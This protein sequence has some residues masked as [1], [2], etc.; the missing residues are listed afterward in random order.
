MFSFVISN[1]LFL[2]Q[3]RYPKEFLCHSQLPTL[4][5]RPKQQN[6]LNDLNCIDS[7]PHNAEIIDVFYEINQHI[8]GFLII[9]KSAFYVRCHIKIVD[10]HEHLR[11]HCIV[12]VAI[13]NNATIL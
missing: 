8:N 1:D 6:I 13:E 3:I 12:D 10:V 2:Y 7:K 11:L 4:H 9:N 5:S